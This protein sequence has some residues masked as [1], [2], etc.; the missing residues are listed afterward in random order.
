MAREKIKRTL[1]FKPII[2]TFGPLDRAS[3]TSILLFHEEIEA[4][5]LMDLKGLYQADAAKEMDVSRPTFS[6]IIKNAH[7]KVA[8]ALISGADLII[9]DQKEDYKVAFCSLDKDEYTKITPQEPLIIIY[10]INQGDVVNIEVEAN[11]VFEE[12]GKPGQLLPKFLL[13]HKVNFFVSSSIGEGLKNSLMA[14]G[15]S[16]VVKQEIDIKKLSTLGFLED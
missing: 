8:M 9:N 3:E 13:E 2:K 1:N 14:K 15:I 16:P 6:R 12:K 11:P 10:H 7:K 5:Y 4:I